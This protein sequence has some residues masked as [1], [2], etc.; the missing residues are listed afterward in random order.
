MDPKY[1]G[2]TQ[3]SGEERAS[4]IQYL[5][6]HRLSKFKSGQSHPDDGTVY[7]LRGGLSR[8]SSN[9]IHTI[10]VHVN[11]IYRISYL[12]SLY[13]DKFLPRKYLGTVGLGQLNVISS[14]YK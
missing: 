10:G 9:K 3:V 7:Q 1:W 12:Q 13:I 8:Q 6:S 2:E 5:R 11:D 14:H 4:I